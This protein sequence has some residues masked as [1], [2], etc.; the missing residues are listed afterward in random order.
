MVNDHPL[1]PFTIIGSIVV[2]TVILL[3]LLQEAAM[4]IDL[5]G[6]PPVPF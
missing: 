3:I 5:A 1:R 6:T 4:L 2:M